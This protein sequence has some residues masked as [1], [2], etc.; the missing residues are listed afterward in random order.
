ARVVRHT[1]SVLHSAL[2]QAL[3]WGMLYRNPT[4]LVELPRVARVEMQVLSPEE[5]GAFL[6]AASDMPF[7]LVFEFA[8]VTGMRPEEYLALQWPDIDLGRGAATIQRVV[9]RRK[10]GWT[11]EE[12][13]TSVS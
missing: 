7:G 13:K 4:D 8:L 5:A 12:P 11:F 2:K 9:V 6:N 10:R 3:K 1:H